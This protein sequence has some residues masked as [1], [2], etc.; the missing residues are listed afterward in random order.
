MNGHS[1]NKP[2]HPVKAAEQRDKHSDDEAQWWALT[3]FYDPLS[4]CTLM[5]GIQSNGTD[6]DDGESVDLRE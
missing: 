6:G 5:M 3:L 4:A 1:Q 2:G